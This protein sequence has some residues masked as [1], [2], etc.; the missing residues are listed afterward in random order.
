MARTLEVK[1]AK[2][3]KLE[4]SFAM[5]IGQL[6]FRSGTGK[7][8]VMQENGKLI[9]KYRTLLTYETVFRLLFRN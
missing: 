5:L 6:Y 8:E 9:Y 3:E 7:D 2:Y 4:E 1:G